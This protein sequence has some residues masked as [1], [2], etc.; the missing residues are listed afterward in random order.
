[1][2]LSLVCGPYDRW[3]YRVSFFTFFLL[4][5]FKTQPLPFRRNLY[6]WHVNGFITTFTNKCHPYVSFL[7]RNLIHSKSLN[8]LITKATGN[9]YVSI[10]R[11][12]PKRHISWIKPLDIPT[13][14]AKTTDCVKYL[15]LHILVKMI[16]SRTMPVL[17]NYHTITSQ[18][19]QP[20]FGI[21]LFYKRCKRMLPPYL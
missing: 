6:S 1:M 14:S 3:F 16:T 12:C 8:L 13:I 9:S 20:L 11:K 17:S 4:P 21:S 10:I 18:L 2:R 5:T 19:C 7:L 15:W